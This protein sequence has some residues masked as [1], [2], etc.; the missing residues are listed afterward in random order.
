MYLAAPWC[1]LWI[2]APRALRPFFILIIFIES[3]LGIFTLSPVGTLPR[4]G[5]FV[6]EVLTTDNSASKYVGE[7]PAHEHVPAGPP[8][9]QGRQP[10]GHW[11]SP[12]RASG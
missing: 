7:V 12:R 10:R 11:V 2:A 4:R 6:A 9:G 5:W 3:G 1:V 8:A